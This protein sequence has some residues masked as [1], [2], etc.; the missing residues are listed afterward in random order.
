MDRARFARLV[1]GL[2]AL[3]FLGLGSWF[4]IAPQALALVGLGADSPA[5]RTELRATYGGFEVGVGLFLAWCAAGDLLRL[6]T[7]LVACACALG[8]FG[9]GRLVGLVVDRPPQPVFLV[10]LAAELSGVAL[11]VLALA[12]LR[13]PG[14][15]AADAA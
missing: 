14:R 10:L 5:A 11:P 1:L 15:P 7:G 6:R 3:L 8:G 12:L 9:A 4:L 2:G 13:A